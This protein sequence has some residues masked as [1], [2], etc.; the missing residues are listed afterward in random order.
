[1]FSLD[2]D[3]CLKLDAYLK[4][5]I[6]FSR[7]FKGLIQIYDKDKRQLEVV[8]QEGFGSEFLA[9]FKEVKPFDPSA[10]GRALGLKTTILVGDVS[11][12]RA[13]LPF[14]KVIKLEGF[15][16]VKAIPLFFENGIVGIISV[17]YQEPQFYTEIN[18]EIP[19]E[20]LAKV[21]ALLN[22]LSESGKP[23]LQIPR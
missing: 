22:G 3:A 12:E 23:V 18:K 14:L 6:V 2:E 7:A 4:E 5:A 8:A 19:N 11:L 1:M 20:L 16:S 9:L 15:R 10:C 13:F 17:H 21:G